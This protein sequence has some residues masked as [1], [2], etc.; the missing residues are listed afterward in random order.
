MQTQLRVG[1]QCQA[2]THS[3]G[4]HLANTTAGLSTHAA[5]EDPTDRILVF[6]FNEEKLGI[7]QVKETAVRMREEGVR[8]A[9]L[10]VQVGCMP[11]S[12]ASPRCPAP[13]VPA[14]PQPAWVPCCRR[15]SRHL[16]GSASRSWH[17]SILWCGGVPVPPPVQTAPGTTH[18]RSTNV[19]SHA[20]AW[21]RVASALRHSARLSNSFS[22]FLFFL[23][24][25]QE[26]FTEAQLRV[27][28]SRHQL[29]PQ[30]TVLG[31]ED[32]RVLMERYKAR[33]RVEK[34]GRHSACLCWRESGFCSSG[35]R[36]E[37]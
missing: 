14:P 23:S 22:F 15:R 10:V 12:P 27:N 17:P 1:S 6:F 34:G 7:K 26:E 31:A 30:H 21:Q 33:G 4:V 13:P 37:A 19:P 3:G 28:I 5:Q 18:Q 9:I 2:R 32:K 36:Q 35:A 25:P 11:A 24:T 16:H 29:V 20:H 8:R